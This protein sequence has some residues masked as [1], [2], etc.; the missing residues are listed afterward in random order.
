[1]KRIYQTAL[2]ASAALLIACSAAESPQVA[3]SKIPDAAKN[4]ANKVSGKKASVKPSNKTTAT[5]KTKA[6]LI[7]ADWCGSCKILDP[8]ITYVRSNLGE[9]RTLPGLEFVRLDYTDKSPEKLYAQANATGVEE[10]VKNYLNGNI[11]TGVLLLVDMD[12]QKVISQVTKDFGTL[13][14]KLALRRAVDAS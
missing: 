6:V 5:M 11:T 13:E 2:A 1:M 3:T 8:K 9:N 10:A 4:T 14:I 12:D 7:Y